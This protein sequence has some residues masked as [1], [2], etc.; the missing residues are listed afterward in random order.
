MNELE[1]SHQAEKWKH[2]KAIYFFVILINSCLVVLEKPDQQRP[3]YLYQ[4]NRL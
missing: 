4:L 1:I 3:T 2:S